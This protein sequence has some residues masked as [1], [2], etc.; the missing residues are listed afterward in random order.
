LG[1]A[2]LGQEKYAAAEPLLLAGY[3]GLREHAE[4]IPPP[5]RQLR[6]TEA[7]ERLVKL[8]EA[9]EK[10]EDAARWRKELADLAE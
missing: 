7:L 3:A 6:L 1:G 10:G 8:Y 4:Q 2:L 5:V 9:L